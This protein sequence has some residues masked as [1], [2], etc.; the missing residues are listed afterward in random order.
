MCSMEA[1]QFC[2]CESLCSTY[3]IPTQLHPKDAT[4]SWECIDVWLAQTTGD[5]S[6]QLRTCYAVKS[7]KYYYT[8]TKQKQIER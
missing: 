6:A 8:C 7:V 3:P 2:E 5:A 4:H 1:T